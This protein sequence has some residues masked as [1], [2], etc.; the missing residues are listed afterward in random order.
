[1]NLHA[2]DRIA[3]LVA[4]HDLGRGET[5]SQHSPHLPVSALLLAEQAILVV[6]DEIEI[7]V[8]RLALPGGA[9]RDGC[10]EGAGE[11]IGKVRLRQESGVSIVEAGPAIG[12]QD[13]PLR[14]E[15]AH[16]GSFRLRERGGARQDED[17]VAA[18]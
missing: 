5:L 18:S 14:H 7:H 10:R 6:V 15:L 11:Q 2:H 17:P 1:M 12:D 16:R 13:T 9:R 4:Q 3:R 8:D